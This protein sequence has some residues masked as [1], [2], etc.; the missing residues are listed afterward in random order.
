MSSETTQPHRL[1]RTIGA[2]LTLWGACITL[3]VC[4]LFSV[5]LYA[6]LFTSLRDGIDTFLEGEVREF[7]VTVNAHP[8]D[9]TGLQRA[10]RRE[11]GS[12]SHHDLAFRLFDENGKLLVTSESQDQVA[13]HWKPPDRWNQSQPHLLFQTLRFHGKLGAYRTCS[14]RVTTDDGRSGTAQA[15]YTLD[16]MDASLRDFRRVCLIGLSMVTLLAILSGRILAAR[17]LRPIQVVTRTADRIGAKSL[18]QRVPRSGTDDELDRLAQTLNNMLERIE[19][20]VRRTQQFTADAS[21]ELRSPLAALRGSAEVALSKP[22]TAGE[23]RQVLEESI[24]HYDRLSRIAEDLLLL[25]RADA[26]FEVVQSESIRLDDAVADVVD[27]YTPLAQDR[28]I[29]LVLKNGAQC[30]IRGDGSRLRQL[31][32]N[33]LDNAIKFSNAGGLVKVSLFKKTQAV[34]LTIADTGEGIASQH[35]PHVFDRFYRVDQARSTHSGGA[36]LGLAICRAITEA[37]GGT[38]DI[39]SNRNEGTVVT[40]TIP[41]GATNDVF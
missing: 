2:R 18:S 8:R 39:E 29:D 10:I 15:S 14:L 40:V 35:L 16:R 17:S 7:M 26:G 30:S 36:G 38:I 20:H 25:A 19:H 1:F 6:G 41:A 31:V 3:S 34:Q 4:A 32:G 11:L 13:T 23:L 28:G 22:R 12:R 5:V 33:L 27:L 37:H 9:D 21:H 24:H